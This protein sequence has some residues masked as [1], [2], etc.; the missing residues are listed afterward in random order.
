MSSEKPSGPR[1]VA[2]VGPY[3]SGKTTLLESILWV[4]GQLSRRGSVD[5]GNSYGDG[6]AEARERRM[7]TELNVVTTTFMDDSFTFL[8][9]PGS[10]EL[11]QETLNVLP[12]I[13]A[14]VVVCEPI[15][16]KAL[17]LAPVMKALEERGIPRLLFVNKIDKATGNVDELIEALKPLSSVPLLL[18]HLPTTSGEQVTGYIDLASERAYHYRPDQASEVI[19][20]PGAFAEVE[21]EA[22]GRMLEALADFD[23]ALMEKILEDVAPERD[24]IYRS[25]TRDFQE[26]R[27]VPVLL[28]AALHDNGVRRLLKALRHEVP[29]ADLAALRAGVEPGGPAVAQVLKT[30]ITPHAGKVSV[31]R[32]WSGTLKDGATLN[33]QRVGSVLRFAVGG[34]QKLAEARAGEVIGLGR[35]EQ[36]HTGDTLREAAGGEALPKAPVLTPV[37]EL[38]IA[39]QRREDDVKLSGAL[40]R[41]VEEDPALSY[42]HRE[43]THELVLLGQGDV[44]L[45]L[46]VDRLKSKNGL[47][48]ATSRPKV[49]YKE[50]I[51]KSVQQHG[52]F[53]RQSGGHGQFG[54]VHLEIAP[55]P[56][57]SGFQFGERVVGGAVPR[58]F[59][60]AVE[61]GVREY[62]AKGPLGFKVV[63]LAVTL[64][65][66]Q[67]HSVDSSEMSFKQAA[68]VTMVEA[69]PKCEPVLLEPILHVEIAVPSE[70]TA[71]ANQV[72]SSRRGQILGF[73]ARPGW[74]GW[75]VVSAQLPQSEIHDLIIELRSLTQGAG[76]Y[77]A[78]FDRLQELTGR[79]AEQ[80]VQSRAAEA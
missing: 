47:A 61:T 51:R 38:A 49:P 58:Q 44:H 35:L 15:P 43:E 48:I 17:A 74:S 66:G 22:R 9:C 3:V 21:Q 71:K 11:F 34:P 65:D 16:D 53:K 5:D 37:Y 29:A 30:S 14:A 76:T 52:R 62:L 79:Q 31:A 32:I 39:A 6:S 63:D 57:G 50:T 45:K 77:N 69:M 1:S 41:L 24:E 42:E 13:D 18:R 8:D 70:F 27:I 72:V 28:G 67:Y 78:R 56:R 75:D 7:G 80:V 55:L 46:A 73:D 2:V 54:D 23:D 10:V 36:A 19:E 68:R 25:L 4:T 64:Y 60:P 33:G 40:A 59:I 26:G 20:L 12:G